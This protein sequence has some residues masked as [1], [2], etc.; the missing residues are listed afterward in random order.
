MEFKSIANACTTSLA[1]LGFTG[2]VTFRPSRPLSHPTDQFFLDFLRFFRENW[3]LWGSQS[4]P[5]PPEI[6]NPPLHM[7]HLAIIGNVTNLVA[8]LLTQMSSAAVQLL[9]TRHTAGNVRQ[10]T[11]DVTSSL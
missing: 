7:I 9:L 4:N 6:L 10:M 8:A 3:Q 11:S 2:I 5:I 1:D